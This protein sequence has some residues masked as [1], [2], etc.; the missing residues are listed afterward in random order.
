MARHSPP[1][2]C[3]TCRRVAVWLDVLPVPSLAQA[4]QAVNK[5]SFNGPQS[6]GRAPRCPKR[7]Q[8]VRGEGAVLPGFR[9]CETWASV[10]GPGQSPVRPFA[11]CV[12]SLRS[13]SCCGRC[14]CWCR[15]RF[16]GAQ[17]LAHWGLFWL[18][19]GSLLGFCCP[20]LSASGLS[21]TCLAAPAR[22]VGVRVGGWVGQNTDP[23]NDCNSAGG[24][25]AVRQ[26]TAPAQAPPPIR[27]PDTEQRVSH[28]GAVLCTSATPFE[29]GPKGRMEHEHPGTRAVSRRSLDHRPT[30]GGTRQCVGVTRWRSAVDRDP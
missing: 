4:T 29:V 20:L 12:G 25:G 14:S 11:C 27:R 24:G 7:T 21:T 16:N 10:Q 17:S 19:Q 9:F 28:G 30:A 8:T 3:V 6:A 26:E 5:G 1:S 22:V 13:V 23:P 2:P 15:F 18:L